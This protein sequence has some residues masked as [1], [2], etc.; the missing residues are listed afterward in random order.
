MLNI[1]I[2]VL[3]LAGLTVHRYL[4]TFWEQ[5]M[6]PYS[7]GFLFFV[8]LFVLSYLIAFSWMFGVAGGVVVA[9]LCFLQVI[10]SAGLWVFLVPG[11]IGMHRHLTIPRVNRFI[12]GGFSYLVP[13]IG[14]LTATNFLVSPYGSMWELIGHSIW[15]PVLVLGGIVIISNVAR[16]IVMSRMV[17][18]S[19]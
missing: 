11:L 18:E 10:Y 19:E 15:P 6:L 8:R 1:V 3:V 4:S 14:I 7:F 12:Y 9:A 13:L 17:K 5:G 16:L 2:I